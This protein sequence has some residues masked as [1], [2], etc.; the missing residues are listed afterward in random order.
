M[1]DRSFLGELELM[2]LL[3]VIYLGEEAYGVPITRELEKHRRRVVSVGS[4]Y[5]TLER[6]EG[7]GLISSSL[8]EA[9][10]E[11]GGKAKKYFRITKAGLKKVQENR[12]VLTD[13]WRAIPELKGNQV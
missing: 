5:A 12:R 1:T 8:G 6:L 4:V 11:R 9:T 10:A 2:I 13:L 3:A 7:K